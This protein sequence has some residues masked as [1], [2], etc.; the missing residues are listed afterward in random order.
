MHI[1]RLSA[2]LGFQERK[3]RA[4]DTPLPLQREVLDAKSRHLFLTIQEVGEPVAFSGKDRVVITVK[5]S[6]VPGDQLSFD[7]N[8]HAIDLTHSF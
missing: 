4:L 1:S 8:G 7:P 5:R 6:I 2:S 3:G